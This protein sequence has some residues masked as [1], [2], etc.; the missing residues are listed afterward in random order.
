MT[1]MQVLLTIAALRK[2]LLRTGRKAGCQLR[3]ETA[4]Q[5]AQTLM[6]VFRLCGPL[7]NYHLHLFVD[8]MTGTLDFSVDGEKDE[9]PDDEPA[10]WKH[11]LLRVLLNEMKY[12][13]I[14]VIFIKPL[15]T[16]YR[17]MENM[18]KPIQVQ[19]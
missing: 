19:A 13:R 6:S 5:D 9:D 14:L 16:A 8:T 11:G 15:E 10:A 2:A 18:E 3:E 4:Q 12:E 17:N 1:M 7:G